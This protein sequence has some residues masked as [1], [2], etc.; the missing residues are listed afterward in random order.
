[1]ALPQG[2]PLSPVC[3]NVY[4]LPLATMSV[5]PNFTIF[6]FAD[7]V[8][9]CGTG[10]SLP[11]VATQMQ[12]VLDDVQAI[13]HEASMEINPAK[14]VA[15]V[16]SLSKSVL[17]APLLR[18]D[19]QLIRVDETITHLG[20]TLDR[21][22]TFSEHIAK[23]TTRCLRTLGTLKSAQKRGLSQQRMFILYRSLILSRLSYGG[24]V[25]TACPTTLEKLDR[26]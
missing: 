8:L 19:G 21:R 2:S 16:L 7:D 1:M 13:C 17:P 18:Y 22:L 5:P 14:A 23:T 6:T 20:V 24:E 25:V 9:V 15:C 11:D 12:G 4:T 10:G 3:F 26:V